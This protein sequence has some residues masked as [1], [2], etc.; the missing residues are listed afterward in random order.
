MSGIELVVIGAGGFGIGVVLAL[1][2]ARW[3]L[4]RMDVVTLEPSGGMAVHK[5][6]V[7]MFKKQIPEVPPD[8]LHMATVERHPFQRNIGHKNIEN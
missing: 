7:T 6:R 2:W 5:G 8:E 4:R 3:K 1:I